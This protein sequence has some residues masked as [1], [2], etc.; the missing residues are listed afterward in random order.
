MTRRPD[1]KHRTVDICP[2]GARLNFHRIATKQR[3][4]TD[5]KR[6]P[7]SCVPRE[8]ISSPTNS[9]PTNKRTNGV[10]WENIWRQ[11]AG[12]PLEV[13]ENPSRSRSRSPSRSR[14]QSPSRSRSRSHSPA[15][16]PPPLPAESEVVDEDWAA[17]APPPPP[18]TATAVESMHTESMQQLESQATAVESMHTESMQQLESQVSSLVSIYQYKFISV[19]SSLP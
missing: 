15:P 17:P 14:S 9:H 12:Q 10:S 13:E 5:G 18:A 11:E 16:P 3:D 4:P 7:L 2:D 1:R 8:A 19:S 6:R